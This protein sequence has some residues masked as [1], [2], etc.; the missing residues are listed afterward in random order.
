M[1]A[2]DQVGILARETDPPTAQPVD[3][4][5]D[6]LVDPA[7]QDHLHDLHGLLVGDPLAADELPFLAQPLQHLLDGSATTVHDHRVDADQLEEDAV[8]DHPLLQ[9]LAE[10]RPPAILDDH[11][12]A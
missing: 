3:Q 11:G 8:G 4:A 7:G 6:L 5:H 9:V 2:L 12:L 10:H 1:R